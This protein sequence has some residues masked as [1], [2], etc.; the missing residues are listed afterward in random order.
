MDR[1]EEIYHYLILLKSGNYWSYKILS[2]I[3]KS[4]DFDYRFIKNCFLKNK[5]RTLNEIEK[6]LLDCKISNQIDIMF[7]C[8]KNIIDEC[9]KLYSPHPE[10][11]FLF[12]LKW[13]LK[14][15]FPFILSFILISTCLYL[16]LNLL[17]NLK[18]KGSIVSSGENTFFITESLID[19]REETPIQQ[20]NKVLPPPSLRIEG[21]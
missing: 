10:P 20:N 8:K 15:V 3:S 11:L 2:I 19:R 21:L 9:H 1:R 16:P 18:I 6:Y 14:S 7:E 17:K 4:V 12:P 13:I 5:I